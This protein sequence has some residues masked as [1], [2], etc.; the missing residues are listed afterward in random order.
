MPTHQRF[1]F[2]HGTR[3]LAS[4][5]MV[6][7]ALACLDLS[8][9]PAIAGST[10][11]IADPGPRVGAPGA[12]GPLP[13][14]DQGE[15]AFFNASLMRFKALTSVSGGIS[16]EPD[17]GLGPR[18]NG[19]ACAGCHAFPAT[20]GASPPVNPQV[21]LATLDGATNKV[22][23]FI[24]LAGPVRVAH[25]LRN[26][27]GSADGSVHDLFTITGR[28]D[29]KGCKLSQPDFAREAAKGNIALR[30]PTSL[31]GLGLIENVRDTGL[32]AEDNAHKSAKAAFGVAGK[33]NRSPD[34]GTIM[35]F[36]WKAQEKSLLSFSGS[37][38]NIEM[39]VTNELFPNERDDN[40]QCLFNGQPEDST[41]FKDA[42]NTFGA[43][44]IVMFAGYMRLLGPP[45]PAAFSISA[46]RG[47]ATFR[48]IGCEACHFESQTTTKSVFT[49]QSN[50]VFH[51][52]SDFEVHAMG[53]NLADGISSGS[54]GGNQFRTAPLWGIGQRLFFLHDGRTSD[55][56]T[57]IEAHNSAGS[58][59]NG[60]IANFNALQPGQAQDVLNFL[61]SL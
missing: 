49:G 20:G 34:D 6:L 39:G 35:R 57:A 26:P 51:P 33:F 25:L 1:E 17:G 29:A 48:E 15:I 18:F 3:L 11:T 28:S 19:N 31:F 54:A 23:R 44:D 56:L 12:G 14:L 41:N 59:A 32:I 30:I 53:V 61:R 55:L 50:L 4:A 60:V 8:G 52:F 27:D 13:G 10:V 38:Y 24:T 22:P 40:P 42:I 45:E 58:E 7:G 21:A 2:P 47:H 43:S 16:G 36:G 46:R 37:A 5:A 9:R